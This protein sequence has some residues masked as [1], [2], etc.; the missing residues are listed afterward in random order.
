MQK[1][2][3]RQ[4]IQKFSTEIQDKATKRNL[5]HLNKQNASTQIEEHNESFA[6]DQMQKWS[7]QHVITGDLQHIF[8]EVQAPS[9]EISHENSI[10]P[11]SQP[12]PSSKPNL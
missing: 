11:K 3:K 2:T 8:P 1:P 4:E 7:K 5:S 9:I 12:N 6:S 10:G